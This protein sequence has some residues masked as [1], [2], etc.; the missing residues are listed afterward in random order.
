MCNM[1]HPHVQLTHSYMQHDSSMRASSMTHYTCDMTLSYA[2]D[3]THS[4]V[5]HDWLYVRHDSFVHDS[6]ICATWLL[7]P[8]ATWL[9]NMRNVTHSHYW[10]EEVQRLKVGG[11]CVCVCVCDMTCLYA[12]HDLFMR[13][14][15]DLS[16]CVTWLI[17]AISGRRFRGCRLEVCLHTWLNY[18]CD[19]TSSYVQHDSFTSATWLMHTRDTTHS[20]VQHSY[21]WREEIQRLEIGGQGRRRACGEWEY[22]WRN[23][24]WRAAQ[25]LHLRVRICSMSI[26]HVNHVTTGMSIMSLQACQ[27]CHDWPAARVLPLAPKLEQQILGMS[28]TSSHAQ[29]EI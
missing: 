4:Y 15:W 17:H 29:R 27:S 3:M 12:W 24:H 9:M 11:V 28:M 23:H 8:C 16:R 5:R 14:T 1:T 6:F 20:Y 19:M 10:L 7:G 21:Q 25:N 22:S 2:C 13:V 18:I 26:M